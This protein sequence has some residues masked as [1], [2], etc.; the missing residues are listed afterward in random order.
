[1]EP[2]KANN[3]AVN[4]SQS[5][6]NLATGQGEKNSEPNIAT[7]IYI[8]FAELFSSPQIQEI[9]NSQN[10]SANDRE[11]NSPNPNS[12]WEKL[13]H[14]FHNGPAWFQQFRDKFT[15]VLNAIGITMNSLA[16]V[17]TNLNIF[18]K[19]L[20][21]FLDEKS[22]W[23]ARYIIPFA[24]AWNGVEALMGNRLIECITRMIPAVSFWSLPFYNFNIVTGISSGLSSLF[25]HVKDR[26]GGKNPGTTIAENTKQVL[27]TSVDILKDIFTG[28]R[29]KEDLKKQM[30]T[31]FM[32][33][34]SGVG[35]AFASKDR[36]SWL[37]RIFG[38]LRNLGG[39][40][41][42]WDLIF[43]NDADRQVSN[44]KRLVGGSCI[45]ASI[46]NI[47][48]RWVNPEVARAFNHISIALDDFGLTYWAQSSKRDND[49]ESKIP[50]QAIPLASAN[51]FLNRVHSPAIK[52]L[53]A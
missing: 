13:R 46:L 24:F 53:V 9:L 26:H 34:G 43:N 52:E 37:A 23:F 27:S 33:V 19:N 40:L 30:G 28:N 32:L 7:P 29:S 50:K 31:M 20:S 10:N 5:Q 11:E 15:L 47:F 45:T 2:L 51:N 17:G 36:D 21:K 38:N 14:K 8:P 12:S 42:D 35:M 22:E 41:I 1:M 6:E 3:W 18:P 39:L 25:E 44:D 48:M 16:V 4:N 49:R